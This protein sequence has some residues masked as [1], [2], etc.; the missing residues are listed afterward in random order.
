MTSEETTFEELRWVFCPWEVG[1]WD[2]PVNSGSAPQ[3]LPAAPIVWHVAWWRGC[4]GAPPVYTNNLS[5]QAGP[6]SSPL[7]K[8]AWKHYHTMSCALTTEEEASVATMTMLPSDGSIWFSQRRA[9]LYT[10]NSVNRQCSSSALVFKSFVHDVAYLLQ[11]HKFSTLCSNYMLHAPPPVGW[12]C[13]LL[14]FTQQQKLN[15]RLMWRYCTDQAHDKINWA[16]PTNHGLK[17]GGNK[18][19]EGHGRPCSAG[20]GVPVQWFPTHCRNFTVYHHSPFP[21]LLLR[22][23]FVSSQYRKEWNDS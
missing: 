11:Y 21:S 14:P 18:I 10:V 8:A 12:S 3:P 23:A 19:F 7:Q 2:H 22:R 9:L 15:A 13:T 6:L 20:S 17:I 16:T 5:P 1:D 4:G